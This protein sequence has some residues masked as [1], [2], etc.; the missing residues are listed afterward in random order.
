MATARAMTSSRFP[1]WI[2]QV[3]G[4]ENRVPD[5][6]RS[7]GNDFGRLRNSKSSNEL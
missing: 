5:H 7:R 6:P 4:D 2:A 1:Q 3:S